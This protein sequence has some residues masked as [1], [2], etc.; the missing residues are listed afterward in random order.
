MQLPEGDVWK[1]CGRAQH[2]ELY[3]KRQRRGKLCSMQ[4]E[5][6]LCLLERKLY[7]IYRIQ[8]RARSHKEPARRNDCKNP[9]R[10][11]HR[12]FNP[13]LLF[14]VIGAIHKHLPRMEH[15]EIQEITGKKGKED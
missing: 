2:K 4:K 12:I 5:R 13:F 15:C 10:P 6:A 8:G 7:S 14:S 1:M 9:P 3:A 11:Q